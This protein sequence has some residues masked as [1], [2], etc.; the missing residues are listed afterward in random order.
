[1]YCDTTHSDE[2]MKEVV[3]VVSTIYV[4]IMFTCSKQ[5]GM[6]GFSVNILRIG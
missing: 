6:D 4:T 5:T 2:C 3:T 1:M